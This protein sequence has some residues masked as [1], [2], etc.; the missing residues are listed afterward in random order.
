MSQPAHLVT[1]GGSGLCHHLQH[2]L[3]PFF[4]FPFFP[5]L[6]RMIVS[7]LFASLEAS[8]IFLCFGCLLLNNRTISCNTFLTETSGL[9]VTSSYATGSLSLLFGLWSAQRCLL[10]CGNGWR[11]TRAEA[12]GE[13][14]PEGQAGCGHSAVTTAKEACRL[15]EGGAAE[16]CK[17]LHLLP[18]FSSRFYQILSLIT[19]AIFNSEKR[20]NTCSFNT[21]MCVFSFS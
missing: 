11:R 15:G 13:A 17:G 6:C 9:R 5:S 10:C 2:F 4:F 1:T 3:F 16:T 8:G 12:T 14:A 19:S 18:L 7:F 20:N 21:P